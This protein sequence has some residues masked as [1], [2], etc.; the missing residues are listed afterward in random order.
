MGEKH[1]NTK[2]HALKPRVRKNTQKSHKKGKKGP[3]LTLFGISRGGR[4]KIYPFF[5]KNMEKCQKRLIFAV[6]MPYFG[7]NA[8]FCAKLQSKCPILC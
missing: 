3:F 8:L 6:K 2:K 5:S 4:G 7:Q 1:E